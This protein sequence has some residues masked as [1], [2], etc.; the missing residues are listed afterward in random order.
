MRIPRDMLQALDDAA[1]KTGRTRNE[2]T[3]QGVTGRGKRIWQSTNVGCAQIERTNQ[4]A[5]KPANM[6]NQYFADSV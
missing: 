1:E 6:L 5:F 4:R 3:R 2:V